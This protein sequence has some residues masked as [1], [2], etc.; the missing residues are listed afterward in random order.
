MANI[1]PGGNMNRK[2]ETIKEL[3]ELMEGD[4]SKLI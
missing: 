3:L 4:V 2:Y 1:N